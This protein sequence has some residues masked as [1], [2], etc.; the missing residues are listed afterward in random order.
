MNGTK[1][2]SNVRGVLEMGLADTNTI[3]KQ[4][5]LIAGTFEQNV[6]KMNPDIA[7]SISRCR[8][9]Q[10]HPKENWHAVIFINGTSHGINLCC[11]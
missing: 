5:K 9:C 11:Y 6:L 3:I 4:Q 8:R 7:V 1:V 2:Y 10:G